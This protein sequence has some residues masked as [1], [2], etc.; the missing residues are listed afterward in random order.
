MES[1]GSP[2]EEVKLNTPIPVPHLNIYKVNPLVEEARNL[3]V[4]ISVPSD[5]YFSECNNNIVTETEES[6]DGSLKPS[7]PSDM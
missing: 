6:N 4:V 2:E 7:P 5:N 1:V 3:D